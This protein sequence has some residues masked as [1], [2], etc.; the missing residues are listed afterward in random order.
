MKCDHCGEEI[1]SY[2]FEAIKDELGLD[3]KYITHKTNLP[4]YYNDKG[5][6][7]S[8]ECSQK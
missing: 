6:Y 7:C 8:A 2:I 4:L 1:V 5:N 3:K